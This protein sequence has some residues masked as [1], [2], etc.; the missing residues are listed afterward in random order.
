MDMTLFPN[1][2][3]DGTEKEKPLRTKPRKEIPALRNCQKQM[4]MLTE[5]R[6]RLVSFRSTKQAK[7]LEERL[8]EALYSQTTETG[9]NGA[10]KV[11]G[12]MMKGIMKTLKGQK[13]TKGIYKAMQRTLKK[14]AKSTEGAELTAADWMWDWVRSEQHAER[15][16]CSL[17]RCQASAGTTTWRKELCMENETLWDRYRNSVLRD[18]IRKGGKCVLV[19]SQREGVRQNTKWILQ[20]KRAADVFKAVLWELAL[21]ESL[22][23]EG[24]GTE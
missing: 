2:Q 24:Q 9:V 7:A 23:V 14:E 13:S 15:M 16:D 1:W 3:Y 11:T 18:V 19:R 10:R 5:G 8:A 22:E 4:K 17:Q 21:E 20:T 6:A 12:E